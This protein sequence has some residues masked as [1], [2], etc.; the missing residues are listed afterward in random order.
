MEESS[1]TF[2]RLVAGCHLERT[3]SQIF[4]TWAIVFTL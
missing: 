4:F 3:V 2:G 1:Y